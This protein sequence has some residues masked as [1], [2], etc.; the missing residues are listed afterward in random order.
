LDHGKL[1]VSSLSA[2]IF[3][4]KLAAHGRLDATREN[5]LADFDIKI[6]DL[7]LGQYLKKGEGP[8]AMDGLLQLRAIATGHGRSLHQVAASADGTLSAGLANGVMRTSLAELT[9]VDLR[10]LG[11]KLAKSTSETPVSCAAVNFRAAGGTL[12]SRTLIIDSEPVMIVGGGAVHL[13][14]ESLDLQLRGHPKA[15]RLRLPLPID[16]R[17]TLVHPSFGVGAANSAAK[18]EKDSGAADC[19]AALASAREMDKSP[20][21]AATAG[22]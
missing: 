10:G 12:T 19:A 21:Q 14:S 3:G 7:Q 17:G 6:T 20:N 13:D 5:P 11:M 15:L 1:V 4:G 9:G 2:L 16:V 22:H 18:T 8:P